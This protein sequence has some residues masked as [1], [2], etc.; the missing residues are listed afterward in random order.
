MKGNTMSKK[1]ANKR[2]PKPTK[3]NEVILKLKNMKNA[4]SAELNCS[5]AFMFQLLQAGL[6]KRAGVQEKAGKGRKRAVWGLTRPGN[7]LASSLKRKE[8]I[9]A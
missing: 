5:T 8:R 1:K 7:G 3:R 4:T 6:V 2:G 9:A